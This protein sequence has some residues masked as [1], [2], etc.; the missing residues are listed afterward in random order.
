M[1]SYVSV[2]HILTYLLTYLRIQLHLLTDLV[3]IFYTFS[4]FRDFPYLNVANNLG[5]ADD[6]AIPLDKF[7][8]CTITTIQTRLL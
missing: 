1:A 4:C 7:I 8:F 2:T 5:S 6:V 3:N